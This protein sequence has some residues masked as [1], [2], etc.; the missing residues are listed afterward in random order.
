MGEAVLEVTPRILKKALGHRVE[1]IAFGI[2][3]QGR[4]QKID[5]S[6]GTI[7]ITDRKNA[8]IIEIERI[9]SFRTLRD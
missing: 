9:A 4:L 8:A 6:S 7:R 2:A 1:V 5:N 3:Y